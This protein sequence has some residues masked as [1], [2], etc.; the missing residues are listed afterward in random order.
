MPN[1]VRLFR[2]EAEFYNLRYLNRQ[3]CEGNIFTHRDRLGEG[4]AV[5]SVG[6]EV[7]LGI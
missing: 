7:Y 2:R 3:P 5:C 6:R 4:R 1:Q